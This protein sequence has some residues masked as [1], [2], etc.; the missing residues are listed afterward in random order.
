MILSC[1]IIL[2]YDEDG[3]FLL[4]G[5][6]C[7]KTSSILFTIC[8]GDSYDSNTL[9]ISYLNYLSV[10]NSL[11]LYQILHPLLIINNYLN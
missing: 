9:L 4:N 2:Y 1:S 5:I 10:F 11:I 3:L 6:I 7:I 8:C